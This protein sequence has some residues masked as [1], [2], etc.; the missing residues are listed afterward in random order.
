MYP[1]CRHRRCR[2]L[3]KTRVVVDWSEV[4]RCNGS[5]RRLR[6]LGCGQGNLIDQFRPPIKR[7]GALSFLS[8]LVRLVT[9]FI[10]EIG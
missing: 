8:P 5:F 1:A 2:R 3:R 7:G 10:A 6:L 9:G 4:M